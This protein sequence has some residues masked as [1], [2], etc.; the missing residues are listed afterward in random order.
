LTPDPGL[1]FSLQ[2]N[3]QKINISP[4]IVLDYISYLIHAFFIFKVRRS[5]IKG[6]KIFEI[7]EKYYFED[8]GLRHSIVGYKQIDIQ[9]ILENI[10]YNHFS[11]LGYE[12]TI[13]QIGTKE[14]DFV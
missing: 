9:K 10:V 12:I 1:L 13:G 6:K 3:I 11:T 5:D 14:I 2:S 8:L 4:N 7:N